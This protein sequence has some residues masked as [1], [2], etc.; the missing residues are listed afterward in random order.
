MSNNH[1]CC[2]L[3]AKAQKRIA[4][5]E[6]KCAAAEVV[7][8]KMNQIRINEDYLK[9]IDRI[10]SE[11]DTLRQELDATIIRESELM[12]ELFIRKQIVTAAQAFVDYPNKSLAMMSTEYDRLVA[13]LEKVK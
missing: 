1:K 4:E 13:A 3:Y 2:E 10:A 9:G 8:K 11:N 12:G 6:S 5:L 7:I